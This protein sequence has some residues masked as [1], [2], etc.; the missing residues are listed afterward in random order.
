LAVYRPNPGDD[1]P[2]VII[3]FDGL[4]E[5]RHRPDDCLGAFAG[6]YLFGEMED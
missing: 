1:F 5:R 4:A 6:A 2:E 3:G